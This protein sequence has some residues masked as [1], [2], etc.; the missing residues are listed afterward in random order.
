MPELTVLLVGFAALVG[1]AHVF[2]AAAVRLGQPAVVGEITCGLVVGAA[3]PDG[4]PFSPAVSTTLDA[5]AQLGLTLFLFAVG[6]RLGPAM[7]AR[8]LR[9]ALG[10]AVGATLVPFVLG[11]GLALWLAHRHAP[12]GTTAFVLFGAAA[13][14]VTAFPVL[15]RI[16]AERGMT[17]TEAGERALATAAVTDVGAWSVL[18]IVTAT[19]TGAPLWTLALAA[20]VLAVL[21]GVTRTWVAWWLPRLSRHAATALVVGVACTYAAA[22]HALG[23]H[24]A[25]GAF[26]AGV[27]LGRSAVAGDPAALV[28]PHS[29]LLVPLYFVLVG[30][31]VDVGAFDLS[32]VGETAA[33]IAVAVIGKCGGAYA[34]ARLAGTSPAA[35]SEFAVLMNTRGVTEI[36]FAG[37]GLGIGVIDSG[38]YTAVVV[39]ALVTTAMTGP[40]LNRLR[41]TSEV[42]P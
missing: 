23:L 13:M 39:M 32:L 19:Q 34:G 22:T 15:A 1:L 9:A 20:P 42:S 3:L 21:V 31:Q 37:V 18:A 27:V 2:G 5:L 4:Q 29:S 12:A 11:A 41:T 26:L 33:V 28:A 6:A 24:A 16:L 10:P 17:A 7:T 30:R 14:A 40:L 38:F 36:I 35:A 8:R 25:F